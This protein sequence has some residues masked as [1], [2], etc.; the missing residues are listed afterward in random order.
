[1]NKYKILKNPIIYFGQNKCRQ[2][3]LSRYQIV[4]G[5]SEIFRDCFSLKV[6]RM[7]WF[8][9]ILLIFNQLLITIM[10]KYKMLQMPFFL[11]WRTFPRLHMYNLKIICQQIL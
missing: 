4:P 5:V 2:I 1:M 8:V 3:R 6:V 11:N 7:H 9:N 10:I